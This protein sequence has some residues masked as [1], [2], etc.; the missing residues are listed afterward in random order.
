MTIADELRLSDMLAAYFS[1]PLLLSSVYGMNIA[2]PLQNEWYAFWLFVVVSVLW[3]GLVTCV[4]LR[5]ARPTRGRV[6]RTGPRGS[7]RSLWGPASRVRA[8]G[9]AP[10]DRA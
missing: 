2:L 4:G 3:A 5:R 8:A 7:G 10:Y 9:G 1:V 6:P